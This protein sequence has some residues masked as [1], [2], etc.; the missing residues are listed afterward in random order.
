M[1]SGYGFISFPPNNLFFHFEDV[2]DGNFNE[3]M[4]GDIVDFEI[5][6]NERGEEVAFNVRKIEPGLE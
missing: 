6:R 4:D 1:K 2:M 3:I 5:R